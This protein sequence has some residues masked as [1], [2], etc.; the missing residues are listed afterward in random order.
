MDAVLR[1]EA[2]RERVRATQA[3]DR[4]RMRW[5]KI[6]S[7]ELELL[8][9]RNPHT[10]FRIELALHNLHTTLYDR[11]VAYRVGAC[12]RPGPFAIQRSAASREGKRR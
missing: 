6:R 5:R 12:G 4:E 9:D 7:E 11:W 8:L 2:R 10:P 1:G 3:G